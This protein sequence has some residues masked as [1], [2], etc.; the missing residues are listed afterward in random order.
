LGAV[1]TKIVAWCRWRAAQARRRAALVGV[2]PRV[3]RPD[4]TAHVRRRLAQMTAYGAFGLVVAAAAAGILAV[5]GSRPAASNA[6][7]S[8]AWV[9]DAVLAPSP[10]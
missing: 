8:A 10:S 4:H 3:Y 1:G 7:M 5:I 6:L 2:S 9:T